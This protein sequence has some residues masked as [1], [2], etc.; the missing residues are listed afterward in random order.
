MVQSNIGATYAAMRKPDLKDLEKAVESLRSSLRQRSKEDQPVD[1]SGAQHNLSMALA[2]LAVRL[3][4]LDIFDEAIQGFERALLVR[5]AT[6][7]PRECAQSQEHLAYALANRAI[8]AGN[9]V[10]SDYDRPIQLLRNAL[11]MAWD[12]DTSK[13]LRIL[14]RLLSYNL[15]QLADAPKIYDPIG[16]FRRS[17]EVLRAEVDL[18]ESLGAK[19]IEPVRFPPS[20]SLERR[21]SKPSA[22]VWPLFARD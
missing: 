6:K 21:F 19:Q 1:W 2:R 11:H 3:K 18:V 15:R 7:L 9:T 13:S 12:R 14:K 4:R 16:R 10:A 20:E 5:T 22:L 8:T 17:L